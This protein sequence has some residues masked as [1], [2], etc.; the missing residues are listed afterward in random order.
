LTEA[1]SSKM[2]TSSTPNNMATEQGTTRYLTRV[3]SC[4]GFPF[5]ANFEKPII[6]MLEESKVE[7]LLEVS[8]L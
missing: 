7:C 6:R 2:Q 4:P 8:E 1:I 5:Y 3:P